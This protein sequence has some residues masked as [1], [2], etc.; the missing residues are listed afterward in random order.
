M[1]AVMVIDTLTNGWNTVQ[2]E[3]DYEKAQRLADQICG[4]VVPWEHRTLLL[5]NG[6]LEKLI[7]TGD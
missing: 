5:D 6:M 2:Q 7:Q 3:S 4:I 1:W